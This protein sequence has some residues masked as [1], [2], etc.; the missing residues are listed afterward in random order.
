MAALVREMQRPQ[1][2]ALVLTGGLSINGEKEP[3]QH[4]QED[5]P[6]PCGQPRAAALDFNNSSVQDHDLFV[7]L[8]HRVDYKQNGVRNESDPEAILS[9]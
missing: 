2:D 6:L 3:S 9:L 5:C 1:P 4:R 7:P 8:A